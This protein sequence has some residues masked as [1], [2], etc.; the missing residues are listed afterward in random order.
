MG[1]PEIVIENKHVMQVVSS[2]VNT[3]VSGEN[4]N[5]AQKRKPA[6]EQVSAFISQDSEIW[7]PSKIYVADDQALNL[8][9]TTMYLDEYKVLPDC[10][11]FVNGQET[12]DQARIALN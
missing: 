6:E 7:Q 9:V 3:V 11:F 4:T 5:Q 12:I 1:E 10:E 2:T 8:K